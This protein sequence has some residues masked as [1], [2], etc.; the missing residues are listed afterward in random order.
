MEK[1]RLIK[2]RDIFLELAEL[3]EE[4][5]NLIGREENGEDVIKEGE[6]VV[7]RYIMKIIEMQEIL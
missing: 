4:G 2:Q 1:E 7:G 5:I 6:A 3:C